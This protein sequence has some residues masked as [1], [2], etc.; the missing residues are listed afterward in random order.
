LAD[1]GRPGGGRAPDYG[2]Y[3]TSSPLNVSTGARIAFSSQREGTRDRDLFVKSVK[4]DASPELLLAG[5]GRQ[6]PHQWLR[7]DTVVLDSGTSGQSG[8]RALWMTR[9]AA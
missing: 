9:G 6:T 5:A 8:G 4:D 7:G 3:A 1:A 2:T